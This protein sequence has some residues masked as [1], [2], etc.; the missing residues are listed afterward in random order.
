[1]EGVFTLSFAAFSDIVYV[2]CKGIVGGECDTEYVVSGAHLKLALSPL[3]RTSCGCAQA[4]AFVIAPRATRVRLP[5]A[6]STLLPQPTK[7]LLHRLHPI[8]R[9]HRNRSAGK[10]SD[11]CHILRQYSGVLSCF[12]P[13]L[14]FAYIPAAQVIAN[15]NAGCSSI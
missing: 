8:T 6:A 1:M 15:H 11:F 4:G 12:L 3:P 2:V 10:V 5:L 13:H 7:L 14:H 9:A